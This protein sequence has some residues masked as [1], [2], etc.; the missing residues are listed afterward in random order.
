[1]GKLGYPYS[2]GSELT[3]KM[4]RDNRNM[5]IVSILVCLNSF[6]FINEQKL[7]TE[8]NSMD[9]VT[10]IERIEFIG[11]GGDSPDPGDLSDPGPLGPGKPHKEVM[12]KPRIRRESQIFADGFP[13]MAP[14]AKPLSRR[15]FAEPNPLQQG[16]GQQGQ[17]NRVN[18]N[19]G[20]RSNGPSDSKLKTKPNPSADELGSKPKTYA[21]IRRELDSQKNKKTAVVE[22]YGKTYVIKNPEPLTRED[23]LAEE[24]YNSIRA[25]DTDIA[26]IAKNL[27]YKETNIK[28]CKEHIFY[29]SHYL[30]RYKGEKVEYR[31][32]DA[33]LR[34]ALAW[35]R[36]EQGCGTKE[37]IEWL[38]HE[39]AESHHEEKFNAGYNESHNRAQKRY[40]GKPWNDDE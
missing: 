39:F 22:I 34:Q 5:F 25:S 7:K 13:L 23:T 31:R 1:M 10:Y 27:D 26:A 40:D 35:K 20:E 32:F 6:F 38:K 12:P 18:R 17:E 28:K 11:R 30:D 29:R 14:Y 15:N 37:D 36:L 21:D 24:L 19:Q 4:A 9:T 33:D 8:K 16:Q 2:Y 3:P